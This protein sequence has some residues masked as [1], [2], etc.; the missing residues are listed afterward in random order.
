V[1]STAC[2]LRRKESEQT[3][4]QSGVQGGGGGCA[5]VVCLD[6]FRAPCLGYRGRFCDEEREEAFEGFGWRVAPAWTFVTMGGMSGG[7]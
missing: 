7:L 4:T 2:F 3:H 6:A 1:V 5:Q